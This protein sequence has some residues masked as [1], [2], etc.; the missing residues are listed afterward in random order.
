MKAPDQA[1]VAQC[2]KE[3]A[4]DECAGKG[5][6]SA[7]GLMQVQPNAIKQVYAVRLKAK[8]G[9]TPSDIQKAAAFKEAKAAYDNDELYKGATNIQIGT[10]YLQ[11]WLDKSNGDIAKAYAGYRGPEEPTYY[12]KIKIT[13]DKMDAD[14]NSIKPLLEMK[15]LK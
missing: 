5:K 6:H 12:N 13:A 14:P 10:E 2:F 11:Y 4:F 1:I 7:Q 3:S 8:L 9:K 15:D